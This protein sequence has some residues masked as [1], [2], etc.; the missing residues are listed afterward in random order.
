MSTIAI[1]TVESLNDG[2]NP[3]NLVGAPV[4]LN[5]AQ[6]GILEVITNSDSGDIPAA[7]LS[8]SAIETLILMTGED[9]VI[10]AAVPKVQ[11][12]RL[13]ISDAVGNAFNIALRGED[14]TAGGFR[15]V[16][17]TSGLI[18]MA[19]GTSALF[20]CDYSLNDNGDWVL[21]GVTPQPNFD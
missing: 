6:V 15:T 13:I 16:T 2:A 9:P 12:S 11:G 19:P 17:T 5:G 3:L 8:G 4:K 1:N 14:S 18:T 7:I 21:Y 20:F 10:H